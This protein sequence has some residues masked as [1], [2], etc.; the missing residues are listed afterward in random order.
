[1]ILDG[2]AAVLWI[3]VVTLGITSSVDSDLN[4]PLLIIKVLLFLISIIAVA[5][6]FFV[7]KTKNAT[8]L[9]AINIEVE[10]TKK[11]VMEETSG[12]DEAFITSSQLRK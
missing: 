5:V 1:M 9:N 11:V 7:P 8:E 6:L 3:M 10:K 12:L 4:S 2:I